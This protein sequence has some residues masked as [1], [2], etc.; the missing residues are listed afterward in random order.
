M[1]QNAVK[2]LRQGDK[3]AAR[4]I[5][6]RLLEN[7]NKNIKFWL[8][9]TE[10]VES[11]NEKIYCLKTV[12]KLD[13]ANAAAKR[14][15][16]LLSKV[17]TTQ[18]IPTTQKTEEEL[19]FQN[20]RK[21]F[22]EG[23]KST[24][25][26]LF[27]ELLKINPK[28]VT[29]WLWM[30]EAAESSSERNYC[31]Q[32]VLNLDPENLAAKRGL[33]KLRELP[34]AKI[35]QQSQ[36]LVNSF[37]PQKS[38]LRVHESSSSEKAKI[39]PRKQRIFIKKINW[40]IVF[41]GIF[42]ALITFI[43]IFG[44]AFAPHDPMKEN[45]SLIVDGKIRTPPYKM[46]DVP[47]YFL[48]TDRYG[49]DL[50]SRLLYAVRPTMIM[51]LAVA[52]VRLLFG[53]IL[54][55]AAGWLE[56]RKGRFLE[57]LLSTSL[58]IPVLI[59]AIFGIYMIGIDK[60][61]PAFI[62]GLG[63]TG[64]AE[65][66]R[67]VS[68]QT[69]AVKT[70]TFVEAA[71]ALGASDRRVLYVHVLRQ[72]LSMLWMLL[73]F[74]IS[75]TLL[76]SAE[77]GFLG[78]YIGGG[79]WIEILDFVTVNVEGL[80]ELGQMLSSALVKISDPAALII[81]GS[82]ICM[83][84]LGFNLL[85]EGL[86]RQMSHENMRGGNRFGFLTPAIEEWL[87]ERIF[88]PAS[89]WVEEN[90]RMLLFIGSLL[91]LSLSGWVV[92]KT[93]YIPPI[94]AETNQ[95]EVAGDHLWASERHDSF[96]TLYVDFSLDSQPEPIWN[97]LIP[98]GPS[99]RPVVTKDGILIIGGVDKTAVA[100][101]P[102]GTILWQTQ[103]EAAPIGTPALNAEGN[104][105]I[106]DANG[107][108]TALD[109]NGNILWRA[110]VSKGRNATSGPIIDSNGNIYLT[111]VEDV[112]AVNPQGEILWKA[113]AADA[114]LEEPPRLSPDQKMIY[115][116]NSV[117]NIETGQ[118]IEVP[119]GSPDQYTFLD[120]AYFSGADGKNYY[121]LGH[122]L[123]GWQID[124]EEVKTE[125]G[126]TWEHASSVLF[127]PFEQGITPNKMLWMFYTTSWTDTRMIW[128][129]SQNLLVGNYR[130]PYPNGKIIAVGEKGEAYMCGSNGAEVNCINITP[131]AETPTWAIDINS[132]ELV[133]GGVIVPGRLYVSVGNDGLY[134]FEINETSTP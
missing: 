29:Y 51:V 115:L 52:G 116:K 72:I 125:P 14:G 126:I 5:L 9:M 65:T 133:I 32:N 10:A 134:A 79:V 22:K 28:N 60:G 33:I 44:P 85:G 31:L 25:R 90:R 94:I 123:I 40:Y 4:F 132:R 73:A 45:Y 50:Y 56:G 1:F 35:I 100:I 77:L 91:F 37:V 66:A 105:Y 71:R 48:G 89:I 75:A 78:Y 122:E 113:F 46:F 6:T 36:P 117:F 20:S 83:G 111:I 11:T 61:L 86:R 124:G 8:W 104:I 54:G 43:A 103:L 58:S 3:T 69:R 17:T 114:Y 102:N 101:N 108:V 38:A 118:R 130:F 99:G 34:P 55:L 96:G 23:D 18:A 129:G 112:Y 42:V 119:I 30:S 127:T 19:L 98:G 121:R 107:G 93:V 88:R 92:Y 15:L 120:P 49:R 39:L 76:V 12:L 41:G 131:G 47:G 67:V 109:P 106:A 110:Q 7:D 70:Q 80:P 27:G 74:E 13:P 26:R 81:V 57:S 16:A 64:W 68:E 97:L 95:L 24:A 59:A 84:V 21:A 82:V 53:V 62:V 87:D 63:I 2:A 128:L